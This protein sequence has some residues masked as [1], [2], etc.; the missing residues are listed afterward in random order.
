MS[1]QPTILVL[2]EECDFSREL[3]DQGYQVW[4]LPMIAT[5]RAPDRNRFRELL[6]AIKRFD[7][8]FLTSR[9]SAAALVD[10]ITPEI[11]T[12]LPTVYALGA[13]ATEILENH[14]IAVEYKETANTADELLDELGDSQF[15]G[16]SILFLRGDKSLRTIPDRLGRIAKV[17]E[18][19]VYE[20][21]E[22]PMEDNPVVGMLRSGDVDWICFFSPSAVESFAGRHVINGQTSP[23]VAVIGET[24]A[25]AARSLGFDVGFISDRATAIDFA[26]GLARHIE[27]FE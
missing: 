13:R 20:T 8:I 11:K 10:E 6:A 3:R 25:R 1:G 22:V 21:V 24:T 4:N 18:V 9:A 7:H 27:S 23:K 26:R 12:K 14:G 19:I 16:T 15:T 2:R 5:R 17:E